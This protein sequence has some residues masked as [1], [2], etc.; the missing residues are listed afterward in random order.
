MASIELKNVSYTYNKSLPSKITAVDD[1]SLKID[2]GITGLIG[3]T[4][5]GKSTLV[6]MLNGLIKP[7]Q[8]EI[9]LIII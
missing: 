3:H 6:Q 4:G 7:D 9:L 2:S 5:S 1:V 8:G